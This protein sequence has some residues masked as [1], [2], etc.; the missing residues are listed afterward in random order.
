MAAGQ[1]MS[2]VLLR[3]TADGLATSF[4]SQ[5]VEVPQLR[6]TDLLGRGGYPQLLLRV[7]YPRRGSRSVPRRPLHDVL[8]LTATRASAAD[9]DNQVNGA[10]R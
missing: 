9:G 1:A 6:L 2:Q 8:T 10:R 5:A 7:G 4:L 3:A